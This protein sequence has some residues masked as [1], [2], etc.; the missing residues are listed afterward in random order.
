MLAL[1]SQLIVPSV[2]RS[3]VR[4]SATLKSISSRPS[5]R[6]VAAKDEGGEEKKSKRPR[7]PAQAKGPGAAPMYMETIEQRQAA[8]AF[9]K[10][11]ADDGGFGG[12]GGGGDGGD[13]GWYGDGR[14][15]GEVNPL[16]IAVVAV[17]GIAAYFYY[18]DQ[19]EREAIALEEARQAIREEQEAKRQKRLELKK[20][21]RVVQARKTAEAA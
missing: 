8:K 10:G 3:H 14:D 12:G 18:K 1:G 20:R 21:I 15:D 16:G 9:R 6:V 2:S 7:K 19:Q 17:A 13:D 11:G 4:A 5:L